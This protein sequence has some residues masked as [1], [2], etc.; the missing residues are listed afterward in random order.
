MQSEH[1]PCPR[2]SAPAALRESSGG[3]EGANCSE[4][5]GTLPSCSHVAV[6]GAGA[7]GLG[8]KLRLRPCPAPA[9]ESAFLPHSRIK[10]ELCQASISAFHSCREQECRPVPPGRKQTSGR[11]VQ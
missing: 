4:Q 7:A 11:A 2:R 9:A 6:A 1:S 3:R 10:S 5:V 8:R